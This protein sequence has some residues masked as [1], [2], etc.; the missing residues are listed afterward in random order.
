MQR[1]RLRAHCPS[2]PGGKEVRLRLEGGGGRTRGKVQEGGGGADRIGQRHQ[3]PA[4]QRAAHRRQRRPMREL[5]DDA[6]L[7]GLD[8][9]DPERLGEGAGVSVLELCRIH[10]RHGAPTPRRLQLRPT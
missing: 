1:R 8:E 2:T 7:G 6:V 10:G 9:A 3:G 4:V 5:G